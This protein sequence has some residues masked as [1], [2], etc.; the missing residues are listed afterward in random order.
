MNA[1]WPGT[2]CV[3]QAGLDL[4]DPPASAS[5]VLGLKAYMIPPH[6]AISKWPVKQIPVSIAFRD[7]WFRVKIWQTLVNQKLG[8]LTSVW[9]VLASFEFKMGR[10]SGSELTRRRELGS[11]ISTEAV[12]G[13]GRSLSLMF[14][15]KA[16]SDAGE[17]GQS[18][19]RPP[20]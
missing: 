18:A 10:T 16:R 20:R 1:C 15:C 12:M 3:D 14:S 19:D 2:C 5:W 13:M 8:R 7:T 4:R 6:L 9:T 17:C 11:W